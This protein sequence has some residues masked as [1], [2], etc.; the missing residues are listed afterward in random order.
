MANLKQD[1]LNNLG[2]DKYY[3]ELKLARLGADPNM[4]YKEKI[5]DMAETLKVLASLDLATQLVNKY[6][7]EAPPVAPEG[8]PQT[9][10]APA[11]PAQPAGAKPHD[12]QSHGE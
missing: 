5:D 7:Q 8:Q 10:Q 2:N 1:L 6:F 12:G 11:Q 3:A 9:E 4:D